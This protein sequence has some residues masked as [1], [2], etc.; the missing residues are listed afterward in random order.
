MIYIRKLGGKKW[1]EMTYFQDMID[2]GGPNPTD[3]YDNDDVCQFVTY[4]HEENDFS[5]E[6][7]Y[8]V[9][10]DKKEIIKVA[11]KVEMIPKTHAVIL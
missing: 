2:E 8:E 1:S 5:N 9:T 7:I 3:F 10:Q 11:I 6:Q 4:W